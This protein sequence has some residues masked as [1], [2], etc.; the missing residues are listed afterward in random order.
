MN[1]PVGLT[2]TFARTAL[3]AKK[4]SP[5]IFFAAGVIGMTTT[6]VLACRA[7]LKLEKSVDDIKTDFH[8]IK[9][10]R[11]DANKDQKGV[12]QYSEQ[13]YY[14]DMLYLYGRTATKIT[15]LYAPAVTLGTLS[16]AA[17]TGSHIQ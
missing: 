12:I 11:E 10:M 2:R 5:H 6:V 8:G 15:I 16:I 17:L 9:T 14:R 1:I 3:K 7:T 4:H 13:D